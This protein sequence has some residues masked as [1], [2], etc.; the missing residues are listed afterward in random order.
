MLNHYALGE[1]FLVGFGLNLL[2]FPLLLERE[3]IHLQWQCNH[4]ILKLRETY[5]LEE[6]WMEYFD[7]QKKRKDW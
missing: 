7:N 4:T 2:G 6:S 1:R 3:F 5:K